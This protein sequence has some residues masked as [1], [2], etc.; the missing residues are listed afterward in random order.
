[1]PSSFAAAVSQFST[2]ISLGVRVGVQRVPDRR[3]AHRVEPGEP[4]AGRASPS[5]PRATPPSRRPRPRRSDQGR[6][7]GMRGGHEQSQRR[8]RGG[9]G[10]Q[11]PHRLHDSLI[12]DMSQRVEEQLKRLPAKPGVYLFRDDGGRVLYIGKAKSLRPRVRSYFQKSGDTR[13]QIGRLP[14]M[15]ADIEVIVTGTE[16]EALARR[17]EPGQ[18]PPAAVQ[19]PPA[20]RQ[21]VPVHRGHARGRVPARDVHARAPPPRGRVLRAVREREEGARDA[22]R[23][24]PRLPVPPVRG[25]E[26]GPPLGDPLPRLPHRALQGARASATSRRRSTAS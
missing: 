2:V 19:H 11:T 20:R 3:H 13:A 7:A 23:A 12:A 22:R 15:V 5:P 25:A 16:A 14:G 10:K 4:S 21:V 17:A 24:Q 8:G 6:A 1:M 9:R 18:A 26:A